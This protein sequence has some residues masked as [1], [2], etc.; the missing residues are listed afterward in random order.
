MSDDNKELE[1]LFISDTTD[2]IAKLEDNLLQLEHGADADIVNELFRAAHSIK[3]G[4]AILDYESMTELAH[5]MESLMGAIREKT[6]TVTRKHID[7]LL[8]GV[9]LIKKNMDNPKAKFDISSVLVKLSA[10]ETPPAQNLE[11][12]LAALMEMSGQL[13]E[14]LEKKNL[15]NFFD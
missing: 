15:I 10:E 14:I 4:S 8:E 11:N 2:A 9:D 12:D 7:A 1:D 13:K 5:A 3:G 6:V